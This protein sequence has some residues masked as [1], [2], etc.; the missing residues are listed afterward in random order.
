MI[1]A[2]ISALSIRLLGLLIILI[3]GKL[4]FPADFGLIAIMELT[5]NVITLFRDFGLA[6]ALIQRQKAVEE[7]AYTT[8]F[9]VIIWSVIL[10]FVLFVTAP[11]LAQIFEENRA[12]PLIRTIGLTLII[13]S[14]SLVPS[15][16][17]EKR[18]AF[19]QRALPETVSNVLYALVTLVL[20]MQGWGVWGVV[21]GRIGQAFVVT[22]L[23]W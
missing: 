10:Y 21:W 7:V 22:I 13:S 11:W 16:L 9:L 4:L 18:L 6:Q 2:S 17:L 14:L 12:V 20:V 19:K 15:A 8:F 23:I 1:W 3:L 5:I